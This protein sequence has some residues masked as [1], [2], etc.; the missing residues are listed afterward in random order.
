[1]TKALK[2]LA[3][4]TATF[5]ISSAVVLYFFVQIVF[6]IPD[7]KGPLEQAKI[8]KKELVMDVFG[9]RVPEE[10][11]KRFEQITGDT[12]YSDNRLEDI[13][14]NLVFILAPSIVIT[15]LVVAMASHF[16][17][18]RK[19]R[20]VLQEEARL[21]GEYARKYPL[22]PTYYKVTCS[23]CLNYNPDIV[24]PSLVLWFANNSIQIINNDY[25]HDIGKMA[26]K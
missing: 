9:V 10:K 5:I 25:H 17:R 16:N 8:T 3:F 1:M 20:M 2:Q 6:R 12:F 13:E 4:I 7:T 14:S 26:I 15:V 24:K 23:D 18:K 22:P 21:R 11:Q 19:W